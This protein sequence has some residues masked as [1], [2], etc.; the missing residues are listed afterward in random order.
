M[1]MHSLHSFANSHKQPW[2]G[3]ISSVPCGS[4]CTVHGQIQ[5]HMFSLC[6]ISSVAAMTCVSDVL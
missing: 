5:L 6:T 4:L 2:D 1:C 3:E